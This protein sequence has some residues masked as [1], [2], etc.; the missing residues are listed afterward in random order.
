MSVPNRASPRSDAMPTT[1]GTN[2]DL[3]DSNLAFVCGTVM[4]LYVK[5]WLGP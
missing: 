5:R 3:T 2:F 4:T 1:H